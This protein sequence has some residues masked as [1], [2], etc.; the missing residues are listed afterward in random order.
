MAVGIDD[1]PYRLRSASDAAW[2][3]AGY[4]QSAGFG[5]RVSDA[6]R[7]VLRMILPVL[8]LCTALAAMYLYMDTALPY[9]ADGK[10]PWLTV[11]HLL[12]PAAF[13]AVHLTNRRFGPSYA[14]AQ[15]VLA[16][17]VVGAAVVFGGQI[18]Q[19]LLPEAAFPS[20]REVA[21]F[22]GAFFV[23]GFLSII[24]FDGARG[25]RWWT[26][27][28]IGSVV[29]SLAFAPIFYAA[30][31]AGSHTPWF[32]HMGIHAVL[33]VGGAVLSL[34]PYW[35]LRRIVQPLPGYGGF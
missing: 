3:Q 9:F 5:R 8:A 35:M 10:T 21:S 25:P 34:F 16:F 27:P 31:F 18:I 23:A 2:H 7:T 33:L 17:A 6:F 24:A 30:A 4:G 29:A 32:E 15:I 13:L 22:G 1:G 20:V 14:F 26:A 12:L 11:S 19:L 28:L